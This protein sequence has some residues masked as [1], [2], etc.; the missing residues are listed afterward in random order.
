VFRKEGSKNCGYELEEVTLP[1]LYHY[2]FSMIGLTGCDIT[3]KIGTKKAALQSNPE[4]HLQ[5]FGMSAEIS[6]VQIQHVE[7]Y[8]VNVV[9]QGAMQAVS[10]I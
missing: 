7:C 6:S 1:I 9:N 4:I 2:I 5:G 3:S 8:L 10:Q